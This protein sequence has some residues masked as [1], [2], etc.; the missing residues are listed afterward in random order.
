MFKLVL[1]NGVE[2]RELIFTT[3]NTPI[4]QKWRN[5]LSKNYPLYE[6]DRF[7]NWGSDNIIPSLNKCIFQINKYDPIISKCISENSNTLQQ[8]LNYLHKF[9]E[10]LR[11]EIETGTTWFNRAPKDIQAAVEQFNIL[12]HKLEANTRTPN[13]PTVVVT[14]KDRPRF[15]LTADDCKHFTFRWKE[16]T[17]YINYCHVGKTVLDIFKDRD[18]IAKSMRPQT[19]YS[20]DFMIKF[21]PTIPY[22]I[23]L[24]RKTIISAWMKFKKINPKTA[25][26]GMIPVATCTS[27]FVHSEMINF[28]KVKEIQCL[29]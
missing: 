22:P 19:H 9:F 1:T 14:F 7:T 18:D 29:K 2:D 6:T 23:Y 11:G 3:Y 4:A 28:N 12:I 8:D 13:H 15:E 24:L 21:G 27:T 16:G 26:L 10:E 17:V 20:A 5:E 25:N